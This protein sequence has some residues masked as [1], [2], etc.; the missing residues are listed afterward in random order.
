VTYTTT[1]AGAWATV[2]AMEFL[3]PRTVYRLQ[4]LHA[5]RVQ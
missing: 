5:G 4:D 3:Q 2:R 1:I